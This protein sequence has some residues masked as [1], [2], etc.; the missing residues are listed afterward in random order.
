MA[1]E[2]LK[3][4]MNRRA[5]PAAVAAA[6]VLPAQANPQRGIAELQ[7]LMLELQARLAS[8]E[9]WRTSVEA[10]WPNMEK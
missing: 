8:M 1:A 4:T 6:V 10:A 9:T 5:I 2:S 3:D 7:A